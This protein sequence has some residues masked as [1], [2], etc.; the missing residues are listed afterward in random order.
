M[1]DRSLCAKHAKYNRENRI[2]NSPNPK[3]ILHCAECGGERHNVRSCPKNP[4][5]AVT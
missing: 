4:D 5:N 2:K 3:R 1:P